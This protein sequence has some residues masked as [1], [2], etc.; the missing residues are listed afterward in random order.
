[1]QFSSVKRCV[2]KS[3][4]VSLVILDLK[5]VKHQNY[6]LGHLNNDFIT[7]DILHIHKKKCNRKKYK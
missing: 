3:A 1:M 7:L 2:K 5:V 6:Y 4:N